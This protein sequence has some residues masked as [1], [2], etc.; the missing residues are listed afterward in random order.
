MI[1]AGFV[2][3]AGPVADRPAELLVVIALLALVPAAVVTLTSF[4]KHQGVSEA[5]HLAQPC[6]RA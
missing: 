5:A 2:P 3:S 4:L 6:L 1:A